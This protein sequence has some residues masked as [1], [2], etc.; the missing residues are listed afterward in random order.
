M[1][2]NYSATKI[3]YSK[4]IER[5]AFLLLIP[6]KKHERKNSDNIKNILLVEPFQM[7][8]VLSLTPL[9]EPLKNKYNNAKIVVLTKPSSGSILKFDS[10]ISEV[11]TTDFPWSDYGVK[12]NKFSRLWNSF[13]YIFSLRKYSFDIGID[14][15]GDI[16]SQIILILAGCKKRIGYTN[17]LHSNINLRGL[18]LTT[19]VQKNKWVHRYEWN[20][21]V[22]SSLGFSENELFPA[23]F[24]SFIPNKLN[25][26]KE[27][28][29]KNIVLHIGGGWKYKRWD[30]ENWIE[31]IIHLSRIPDQNLFVIAGGGE[32]DILE[33]I[34][35]LIPE[36]ENIIFKVT[37]FE[38][39]IELIYQCDKF[40][41]L[42]SGPMNLAVCLN[43]PVVAL[44]GPGD[45]TMWYPLNSE[46]K[47]IHRKEKFPCNPCMQTECF[48]S[49]KNCMTSI[50]VDE[51]VELLN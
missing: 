29:K 7:G 26:A 30:E 35:K 41:G 32:K 43:K 5:V 44:F 6:F 17:Y 23:K 14:T 1:P 22:L 16:R 19:K 34:K 28:G 36:K 12:S 33:R 15:R 51:V 25:L 27:S 46:S 13:S 24:P 45:S 31:L 4:L 3:F 10:R 49:E 40:V 9:I 42:D 39:L 50:E 20:L 47:F 8:D 2:Y 37:S 11:L 21:N 18:L 48:Y 38:E